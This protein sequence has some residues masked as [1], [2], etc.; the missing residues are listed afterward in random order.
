MPPPARVRS[1][2]GYLLL[3]LLGLGTG[4][5]MAEIAIRIF[6]PPP[7]GDDL[8]GLHEAR[9]DRPWLYGL[10]PGVEKRL[11]VSGQVR[12]AINA[13]GFRG[14]LYRRPKPP[15]TFRILV[16]GDSL[17]FGYGVAEDETF[18]ALLESL[19]AGAVPGRTVEVLNLGVNGYNAYT[20]AALFDDVGVTFEPDLVLVAFCVN[21][22]D[23][24][25]LHFDASTMLQVG[26]I[27]DEAFPDPA[28][29]RKAP[30][31]PG[32]ASRACGALRACRLLGS[33]LLRQ[34]GPDNAAIG[35]ALKVHEDPAPVELAWLRRQYDRI[36][37][38]AASVG[39]KFAVVILPYADQLGARPSDRLQGHLR[40]LGQAAGW[41]T[42]DLLAAF[43][44]AAATSSTL[45]MDFWHPTAAGHRVAA[46]EIRSQLECSGLIPAASGPYPD[47]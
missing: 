41:P 36:A 8:R 10:R 4:L 43:R 39:A 28:T 42:I 34:A 45:F 40:D 30:Q 3:A 19:L 24:P 21:D 18:P 22:L 15:A 20:E 17:A 46:E 14:R 31:P 38:R 33:H 1:I 47:Q 25:T 29:R 9:P 27:P 2:L 11:A 26:A 16:L 32:L 35:A 12:Y 5:A 23:D 37:A 44:R 6:V 13:D 7:P